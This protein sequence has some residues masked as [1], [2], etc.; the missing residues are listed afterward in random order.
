M[1]PNTSP[2]FEMMIVMGA[3]KVKARLQDALNKVT[4]LAK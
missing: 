2:L 3:D 1:L 4:N